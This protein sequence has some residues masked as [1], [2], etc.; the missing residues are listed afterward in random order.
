MSG[1]I[2][3]DTYQLPQ[4]MDISKI[5]LMFEAEDVPY[6]CKDKADGLRDRRHDNGASRLL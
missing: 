2:G 5:T 1:T 6:N 4:E 3:P